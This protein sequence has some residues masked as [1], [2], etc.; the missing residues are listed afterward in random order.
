MQVRKNPIQ[1]RTASLLKM[2]NCKGTILLETDAMKIN[3]E[4]KDLKKRLIAKDVE[5]YDLKNQIKLLQSGVQLIKINSDNTHISLPNINNSSKHGLR[6]QAE[7]MFPKTD[8]KIE[9]II[10]DPCLTKRNAAS[11][12]RFVTD[13]KSN[14]STI[15]LHSISRLSRNFKSESMKRVSCQT[16][17]TSP[18]HQGEYSIPSKFSFSSFNKVKVPKLRGSI[19]KNPRASKVSE[20]SKTIN[21]NQ[22][23]FNTL[24]TPSEVAYKNRLTTQIDIEAITTENMKLK[25]EVENLK[26]KLINALS[27]SCTERI[28]IANLEKKYNETIKE[29][30]SDLSFAKACFSRVNKMVQSLS[31]KIEYYEK[32]KEDLSCKLIIFIF[33]RLTQSSLGQ[34]PT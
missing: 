7:V 3:Y 28:E 17:Q 10:W 26:E 9:E 25:K 33:N 23:N 34:L 20:S 15:D 21:F 32:I 8:W 2:D 29:L 6:H 14:K 16:Q 30:N 12:L 31:C 5:I 18:F 27:K 22:L 4:R 24:T 13:N 19:L 11:K 1:I